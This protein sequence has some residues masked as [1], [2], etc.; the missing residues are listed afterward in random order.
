MHQASGIPP[1]EQSA[2]RAAARAAS[3]AA[4]RAAAARVLGGPAA[5][6]ALAGAGV[7]AVALAALPAGAAGVATLFYAGAGALVVAAAPRGAALGLANRLTL[8]RLAGA[9]VLAGLA[10]APGAAAGAGGWVAAGAAAAL[11]ALDGV[12][13]RVARRRGLVSRFGARFDMETDA[14]TILV[15]AALAF[16]L[17][18]A[19]PWVLAIGALRYAFVAAG[20][21]WPRL[22]RPLP[23]S[24]RRRAVCALQIAVLAALLAPPA[25]PPVSSALAAA[26][27][28]ALVWSFAIDVRRLLAQP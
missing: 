24:A 22:A 8:A 12:D 18:K 14:F 20:A 23:E 6:V 10:V 7:A 11:L 27:L 4:A 16:G 19:G 1:S 13:G 9:A 17:G 28:A 25:A 26:A 21:A 2:T 3:R 5:D 15:L